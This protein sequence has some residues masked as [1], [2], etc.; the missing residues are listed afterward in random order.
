MKK[1]LIIIGIFSCLSGFG[2]LPTTDLLCSWNY[3]DGIENDSTIILRNIANEGIDTLKITG[4]D[5]PIDSGYISL[6]TLATIRMRTVNIIDSAF[7][8][9]DVP[10]NIISQNIDYNNQTFFK[11]ESQILVD[12]FEINPQRITEIAIYSVRKTG[13][14]SIALFNYFSVPLIPDGTKWIDPKFTGTEAGTFIAPY[15]TFAAAISATGNNGTIFV[16]SGDLLTTGTISNKGITLHGVGYSRNTGVSTYFLIITTN[17]STNNYISNFYVKNKTTAGVIMNGT[18]TSGTYFTNMRIINP[19]SI[20]RSIHVTGNILQI[21]NCVCTGQIFV[22]V[23]LLLIKNSLLYNQVEIP[24]RL[25]ANLNIF[26]SNIKTNNS[27]LIQRHTNT[28]S[29]LAIGCKFQGSLLLD[30]AVATICSVKIKKSIFYPNSGGV[31][32]NSVNVNCNINLELDSNRFINNS[33]TYTIFLL[34]CYSCTITNTTFI[35][36]STLNIKGNSNKKEFKFTNNIVISTFNIYILS[37]DLILKFENNYLSSDITSTIVAKAVVFDSI[38]CSVVN[39]T[40]ISKSKG[41]SYPHLVIGTE[42]DTLVDN[43]LSGSVVKGNVFRGPLDYGND[44]GSM[45]GSFTWS[46]SVTWEN[47]YISGVFLAH[48]LKSNGGAFDNIITKELIYNCYDSYTIKGIKGTKIYNNTSVYAGGYSGL[49][50]TVVPGYSGNSLIYNNIFIDSSI[51][52]IIRFE[53]PTDSIGCRSNHNVFYNTNSLYTRIGQLGASVK[54]FSQWQALGYDANSLNVDPQFNANYVPT[55][56][57]LRNAGLNLGSLY[58]SPLSPTAT[59][60]NPTT[61]TFTTTWNPGAFKMLSAPAAIGGSH[62]GKMFL[63]MRNGKLLIN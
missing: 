19:L 46:Q 39:N 47:N 13:T 48:V 20:Y 5:Y 63:L 50:E 4:L 60:P 56:E 8:N 33:E 37:N 27:V 21:L 41:S 29:V 38:P 58:N 57:L 3:Q 42:Y 26:Y 45:H 55:N 35:N 12:S 14:D 54:T 18:G 24:V 22:N 32:V 36:C 11:I 44:C 59:W 61:T 17:G 52:S 16:K 15:K 31:F 62:G 49:S 34:G 9:H 10:I 7:W 23:D 53:T 30:D 43:F 2:Q 1:L 6:K 28:L 51:K 25:Y 40:V